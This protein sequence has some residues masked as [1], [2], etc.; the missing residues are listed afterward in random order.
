MPATIPD[1][2]RAP[3]GVPLNWRDEVSGEL[4]AAVHQYLEHVGFKQPAPT[5]QQVAL[6]WEYA[7]H[8]IGA[9]CWDVTC[10]GDL[11]AELAALREIVARRG[12]LAE[13]RAYVL[14]AREIALDP[15]P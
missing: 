1:I 2:Y 6:L 11:T 14:V 9:P 7:E 5:A 15:F 12:G 4:S 13:L 8:H 10:R 3:Y